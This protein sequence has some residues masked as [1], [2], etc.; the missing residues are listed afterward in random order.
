[1]K[2]L[3]NTS[4]FVKVTQKN[5]FWLLWLISQKTQRRGNCVQIWQLQVLSV[6]RTN[7]TERG[8][9]DES[10]GGQWP[11][12]AD[13]SRFWRCKTCPFLLFLFCSPIG[14]CCSKS[15]SFASEP[16]SFLYIQHTGLLWQSAVSPC[17]R[18]LLLGVCGPSEDTPLPEEGRESSLSPHYPSERPDPNATPNT[19]PNWT[20]GSTC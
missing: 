1:M 16:D 6:Q 7:G 5:N 11:Q 10:N 20:C 3:E 4:W 9:L 8:E 2:S 15:V 17:S 14:R 13:V 18:T 19:T 12:M